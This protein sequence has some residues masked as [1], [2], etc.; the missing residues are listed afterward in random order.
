[1]KHLLSKTFV[2][3]FILAMVLSAC[4]PA[5]PAKSTDV[6]QATT[7]PKATDAPKTDLKPSATAAPAT[8]RNA[9]TSLEGVQNAAIQIEAQ[10][11][12]IDPTV[13]MV[14]N[15][16]G[17]GTGFIIDP[18]G[19]AVTNNHVVTGAALLKVWV[20]GKKD[21]VY[22]ARVLGVSECSDLAVIKIDGADFPYLQWYDGTPKVGLEVYAAGFPLGDP[23]YTLTKGIVSKAS[24]SGNTNWASVKSVLEHD[25]RINPGNSGGPLV[26]KD[27]KVVGV[28]YAHN[29][30]TQ[31]FA[32]ARVEADT[33]LA[34]LKNGTDVN[35][36]GVNGQVVLSKELNISGVWV[37]SVKSGSPADKSGVK[38]GDIIFQMEGLVLGTDGTMAD[39]CQILRSHK[40]S[41]TLSLKVIRWASQQILEGQLNGRQ[42]AVTGS[43]GGGTTNNNNNNKDTTAIVVDDSKV[44]AMEVP[45]DWQYD[46]SNWKNTWNINGKAYPFTAQ[47][48][49]VSP[50]VKAYNS[51]WSMPGLLIATS[52]DW[53]S[54][55]GYANLLSGV[56]GGY[57]DCQPAAAQAYKDDVYEGQ[58][59]VYSRCGPKQT[60]AL[61]M[62]VRPI[63][64]PTAYLVLIEMKYTSDAELNLLDAI[65]TSAEI[66]P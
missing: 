15:G 26:D 52:R 47:S 55:G 31:Y 57:K 21:K 59:M 41:D 43:F 61:V 5:E 30:K 32:I 9:V 46:G 58:I 63:T 38:A 14:V 25:A 36:I 28:N 16:A 53:A 62:A 34:D 35:S 45:S 18:S 7:A 56:A 6:P 13:G 10:G 51:G 1:M 3:I 20:G 50:D 64:A 54:M 42:L 23:E 12:F 60:A 65:L 66:N 40:S 24:A 48:L 8:P 4:S 37:S 39:Y 44:I 22:N 2:A 19:I 27:G 29:D 33:V 11:T 49:T 17:R